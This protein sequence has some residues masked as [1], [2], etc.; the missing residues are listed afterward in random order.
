MMEAP[1]GVELWQW[2]PRISH[3]GVSPSI[4]AG[5]QEGDWVLEPLREGLGAQPFPRGQQSAGTG[6]DTHR[7]SGLSRKE[8]SS[9]AGGSGVTPGCFA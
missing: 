9:G 2:R 3:P 4:G 1:R 8:P 5:L 7:A 6:S